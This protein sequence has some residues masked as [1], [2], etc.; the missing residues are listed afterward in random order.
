MGVGTPGQA[1]HNSNPRRMSDGRAA[2]APDL[3]TGHGQLLE[4]QHEVFECFLTFALQEHVGFELVGVVD[5]DEGFH[6]LTHKEFSA[7][8]CPAQ[9]YFYSATL[10]SK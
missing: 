2:W 4:H 1:Q 7:A 8:G 9:H 10:E 5:V 6:R 3:H